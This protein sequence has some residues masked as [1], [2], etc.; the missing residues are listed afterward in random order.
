[1]TVLRVLFVDDDI[2]LGDLVS[3]ALTEKGYQVHFQNSLNGIES[4]IA[5]FMPSIIIF[6]VEIGQDNGIEKAKTVFE[7]FPNIPL[8]FVSS[9]IEPEMV[10]KG[11]DSG[12]VSYIRKPFKMEEL[13][14][15]IRRFAKIVHPTIGS[16]LL[17]TETQALYSKSEFL[18][19]LSNFE[20]K[21]LQL[22]IENEN[23]LVKKTEI[24]NLL[25]HTEN[26]TATHEASVSNIISHLRNLLNKD[27]KV[28]LKTIRSKGYQIIVKE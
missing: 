28:N 3:M 17:N 26:C 1:M 18:K 25:W 19:Q 22:L 20:F 24:V 6:D 14:V 21:V 10:V 12:G 13:E 9:H 15:Y 27:S 23:K 11:I 7:K 4:T 2:A 5:A 16:F 8:L